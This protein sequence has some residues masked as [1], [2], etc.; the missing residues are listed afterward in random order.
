MCLSFCPFDYF[1]AFI[2][3]GIFVFATPLKIWDETVYA[4]L[5]YDL[6]KNIL[7]YSVAHNGWS[8]FI[9][10]GGDSFYAWPKIGFRAPLLPYLLSPIYFFNLGFLANFFI[11]LVGALSVC[12]VYTLGKKMFNKKVALYSAIL[13]L[14]IPLHIVYSAK[15]LT[16]VLFTFFVLLTFLSFLKGYEENNKKHKILFGVFLALALLSRYTALWIMPIFLLYFLVKD[17]SLKFLKDKYLWYS[18][19]AFFGTLIPWFIYGIF[20]YKNPIGAFIHGAKASA[21]WGGLQSW[22][23]FFDYWWQMFSMIGIIFVI[24]LI[25][26]LYKK[27]FFKKEIY[28]LLIWFAFFLGM[29]IYMPHKEDRFILAIVPTIALISGYFIDKIKKYKKF[30]LLGII[31]ISLFSLS[32]QFYT[33]YN[34]SYTD[35]NNCFLEGNKFLQN[36]ENALIVTDES[37][38]V[39]YYTRQETH[40]YPNPRNFESL[41]NMIKNHYSDKNS[42]VF[43]TDF[44]MPLNDEEHIKIKEDLDKN[45]EKVFECSKEHGYSAVYEIN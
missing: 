7:D 12:L 34:N 37:A 3:R 33:T 21:Y 24:A 5:G 42:F 26:I 16:G 38:I 43:F 23:F 15:I 9:P 29:A 2:I 45:L 17:K 27:D 25:Y 13:F 41:K 44:D 18:I 22:H 40:F 39:Y 36:Q 32:S 1:L 8:D 20:E 11:V 10:S 14:L 6:S 28:L 19:L 30:I 35:T 4:N 31:I